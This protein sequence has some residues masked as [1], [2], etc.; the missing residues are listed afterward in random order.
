[1]DSG[2]VID[3]TGSTSDQI[4]VIIYDPQYTPTLLDQNKHRYIPAESVY[5]V[6]EVK[7]V[8]N[9]KYVTYAGDKAES[10]RKLHRTSIEIHHAGGEFPPK[11]LFPII[12]GIVSNSMEWTDGFEGESFTKSFHS[13]TGDKSLD[14]CLSVSGG[15]FHADEADQNHKPNGRSLIYFIF[16]LLQRLQT[17]GTVPAV[18]WNAYAD[19]L[20]HHGGIHGE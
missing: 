11:K 10:V 3:S 5:A 4:D 17:L 8:M 7:P 12:A 18:D 19:V 20:N 16:R 9:K 6:F 13:L 14:F 1:V 2:I 15:C